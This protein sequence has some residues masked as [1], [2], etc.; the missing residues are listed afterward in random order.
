MCW[1]RPDLLF[2][3]VGRDDVTREKF[4]ENPF[5]DGKIYK[6]GDLA[7]F[8]PDGQICYIGRI[9]TQ[10]KLRGF[11]IELGEID[12]KILEYPDIKECVTVINNSHI[13]SYI[14]SNKDISVDD[15]K[16][17]LANSLPSFM[18][19]SFI[20]NLKSLPLTS[21]GKI[22]KRA[23]PAPS[24]DIDGREIIPAR[25]EIDTAILDELKVLL[26]LDKISIKDSFFGIGG[27]SLIAITLI[28][29]LSSKLKISINVKDVFENPTI[30]A[31]SDS[32]KNKT[33]LDKCLVIPKAKEANFYP[34]SYAQK[35]IYYASTASGKD[36]LAYNVSGGLLFYE[37][38]DTTR[39]QD[40]INELIKIHPSF[41]TAFSYKD[42]E[43]IQTVT[44]DITI[45]VDV[46]YTNLPYEK[47][48][49]KFPKPFDLSKAPLLRAKLYIINN[50]S[51]ILV[52]DSHHIILDGVSFSIVFRDFYRLYHGENI[53]P[54]SLNYTDYAVWEKDFIDSPKFKEIDTFWKNSLDGK[55][56]APL[57]LPY[58]FPVSSIKTYHGATVQK[59]LSK[60]EF[61]SLEDL[62]KKHSVSSFSVFLT[63]LYIL[64]YQYTKATNI[65]V[66]SPYA[67]R[68]L[69]ETQ[70]IV[71]Y[72][73]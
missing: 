5:G 46:E 11:R 56:F 16:K 33:S 9:D 52:L 27:D 18:I 17:H 26:N 66:G 64:L 59:T 58:D 30:E 13:C 8:L 42:G 45:K 3:Y 40:T 47:L 6:T 39:V 55:E 37:V 23:L 21:G 10:V 69:E 29:H 73:C 38:L 63:A 43:I 35:R 72:V 14:A 50:T 31:F 19:P 44:E 28:T 32:I 41:R 54:P 68:D 70:D 48:V 24:M 71:R 34:A 51:S 57:N 49:N 4:I 22:D 15:L 20:V 60:D 7:M 65:C 2:G 67:G 1:W 53:L 61:L 36:S 12:S 62:A 25:N